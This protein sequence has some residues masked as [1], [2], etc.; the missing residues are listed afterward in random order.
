MVDWVST[1]V[2][3]DRG[4]V[5]MTN[6]VVYDESRLWWIGHVIRGGI[7]LQIREVMELEITG[8]RK[9][10]KP[11]KL[12]EGCVEKDLEWSGIVRAN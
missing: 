8:E 4:F 5:V 1:D 12:W 9:K 10:D 2:L 6:D 3:R 11:R 7:N